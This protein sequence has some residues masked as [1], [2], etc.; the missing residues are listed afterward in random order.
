[1][2]QQSTTTE[3]SSTAAALEHVRRKAAARHQGTLS[4]KQNF[5]LRSLR[6]LRCIDVASEYEYKR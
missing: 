5:E 2:Y 1:M 4:W 6:C 3:P